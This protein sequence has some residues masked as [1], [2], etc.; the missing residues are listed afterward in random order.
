MTAT[1]YPFTP[2]ASGA[3]PQ[4]SPT[5][6]GA[7]YVVSIEWGL[8][9]QRYYIRCVDLNGVL[10]Y[11]QALIESSPGLTIQSLAWSELQ[12]IVQGVTID[13][14]GYQ[15]GATLKLT[16]SGATPDE[17]N[18]TWTVLVTGPSS[19]SYPASFTDD[20]IP[21]TTPGI[22]SYNIDMNA[23]YGF[24]TPLVYSSGV[25]AVGS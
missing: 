7:Q 16:V 15:I 2:V 5:F 24:S 14:H 11:Y 4:F 10:I 25:F 1:L 6:D 3:P 18:G 20:P 19:F 8:F 22:L 13:P 21:A 9:G 12:N 23:A 17:Y